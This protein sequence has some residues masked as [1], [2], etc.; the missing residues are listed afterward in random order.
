MTDLSRFN[1][2][3]SEVYN[4]Q[5]IKHST[6]ND[7][8]LWDENKKI[9]NL[10][11][12][13][14]YVNLESIKKHFHSR[15][16]LGFIRYVFSPFNHDNFKP[17]VPV[18]PND[19]HKAVTAIVQMHNDGKVV[20]NSSNGID[21][22]CGIFAGAKDIKCTSRR[23][24]SEHMLALHMASALTMSR[25]EYIKF[26][27]PVSIRRS[28]IH[29]TMLS[30]ELYYRHKQALNDKLDEINVGSGIFW[31]QYFDFGDRNL[32]AK[33][34]LDEVDQMDSIIEK[35]PYLESDETYET[36]RKNIKLGV[37]IEF[38]PHGLPRE[39]Y[40]HPREKVASFIYV[41]DETPKDRTRRKKEITTATER[42]NNIGIRYLNSKIDQLSTNYC[43]SRLDGFS[44]KC[45]TKGMKFF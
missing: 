23:L 22:M 11:T 41:M 8:P 21:V 26:M 31:R 27:F 12:K 13:V 37:N 20:I 34:L 33:F 28:A 43:I 5:P 6:V 9:R 4:V 10:F 14:D 19:N 3:Y 40:L 30:S 2:D 32:R 24:V 25:E 42:K 1:T 18:K 16:L 39:I 45:Y 36:L 15:N 35:V 38:V 44:C 7:Y 17:Q 29:V